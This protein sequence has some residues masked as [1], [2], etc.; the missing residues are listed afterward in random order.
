MSGLAG[1]F[2][3]VTGGA[4]ELAREIARRLLAEGSRVALLD[5]DEEGLGKAAAD[6]GHDA[7]SV[8]AAD[9]TDEGEM[10]AAL[11]AAAS[12][13]GGAIDVLVNNAGIE[14]PVGRIVDTDVADLERVLR[15]NVIG[16]FLG[17]KHGLPVVRDGGVVVNV[18]STASLRGAPLVAPYVASKHAVVGLSRS[19]S[20]EV[21]DRGIRVVTV[22]PGPLDGRMIRELDDRRRARGQVSG[23]TLRYGQ[24]GE[25]AAAITFL[26]SDDASFVSGTE[27]VVDGGRLA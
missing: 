22:C 23:S 10:A 11:A 7:L 25:V 2:A 19:A 6:L 16:V 3:V 20:H 14:G 8:L 13:G 9:V 12:R 17:L 26:A 21:A 15:V 18:G 4:G 24:M 5:R 1:R 27:L